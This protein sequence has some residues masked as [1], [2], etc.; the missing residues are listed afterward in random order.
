MAA[1]TS[2]LAHYESKTSDQALEMLVPELDS[3]SRIIAI[4][5]N[6]PF[7]VPLASKA[8]RN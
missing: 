8:A 3:V 5:L 6:D 4:G 7:C 1:G 2:N